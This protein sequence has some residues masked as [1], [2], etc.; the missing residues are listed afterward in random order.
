MFDKLFALVELSFVNTHTLLWGEEQLI[1]T[2]MIQSAKFFPL[3]ITL[4][5]C[6]TNL[7]KLPELSTLVYLFETITLHQLCDKQQSYCICYYM[8]IV[9]LYYM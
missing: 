2:V 4:F 1:M 3:F 7:F 9:Y 6:H 5:T 8:N